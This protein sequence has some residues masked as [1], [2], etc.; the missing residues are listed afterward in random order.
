MA[1]EKLK[2]A[3]KWDSI[4]ALIQIG[5]PK[6][7]KK[8]FKNPRYHVDLAQYGTDEHRDR[9]IKSKNPLVRETVAEFGNYD[10]L[11]KLS[12]DSDLNVRSHAHDRI[13]NEFTDYTLPY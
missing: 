10:H 9:L 11:K 1:K 6:H 3:I 12:H 4:P 8:F 13:A 7:I 2:S 5:H